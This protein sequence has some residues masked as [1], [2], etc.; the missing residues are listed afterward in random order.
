M[1]D[2]KPFSIV[3][4]WQSEFPDLKPYEVIVYGKHPH[5]YSDCDYDGKTDYFPGHKISTAWLALA[6]DSN[7]RLAW[8]G[9]TKELDGILFGKVYF[10]G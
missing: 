9:E 7:T 1:I 6:N 10:V 3:Q 2:D 4:N 5:A 8:I